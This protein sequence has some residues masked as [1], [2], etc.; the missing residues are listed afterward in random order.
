MPSRGH[1]RLLPFLQVLRPGLHLL[2][3]FLKLLR[4]SYEPLGRGLLGGIGRLETLD[5]EVEIGVGEVGN[6]PTAAE[7]SE[8]ERTDDDRRPDLSWLRFPYAFIGHADVEH[9]FVGHFSLG[10]PLLT[11]HQSLLYPA[12]LSAL[13]AFAVQSRSRRVI[14]R[15]R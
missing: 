6:H 13:L 11:P 2:R 14:P 7:Q 9:S 12:L 1:R 10:H 5:R 15:R 8:G 4:P 3:G